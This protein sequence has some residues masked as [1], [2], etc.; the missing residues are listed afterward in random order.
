M[1]GNLPEGLLWI[2]LILDIY[3]IKIPWD[4]IQ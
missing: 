3:N 1:Y 4:A 2:S